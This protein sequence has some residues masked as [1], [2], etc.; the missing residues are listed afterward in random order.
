MNFLVPLML[1]GWVPVA[2][3]F[4]DRLNP[5]HAVLATVIGGWL[6]LP[7]ASYNLAGLPMFDKHTAIALGL[8]MG[9]M[10][11]GPRQSFNIDWH[12]FDLPMVIYCLSPVVT[13]LE[14]GL[15]IY[16]GLS[17]SFYQATTWG[18]PYLAGRVYFHDSDSL[19]DLLMG[20]VIGGLL[21][22]PLCLYEVR[23]SPQLSNIFYGFFPH[24]FAQHMR[25]GGFRPI[26]FLQ[27]GLMVAL[28]MAIA[29]TAAFW[30]WRKRL[31]SSLRGF[32]FPIPVL[33]LSLIVTTILCKSVNG[34]FAL[35]VGCGAYLI[36]RRARNQLPLLFLI[37][38]IPC[39]IALRSTETIPVEQVISIAE[40]FV[41]E[42]RVE[43]F[44]IRLKQEQLFSEKAWTHKYFGW[45]G[46]DRGWPTD[47]YSGE[48][49][50]SMIDSIWIITFSMYGLIGLVS[51]YSS[52]LLGP[53]LA[54]KAAAKQFDETP[55][56]IYSSLLSLIVILF[57][58]DTLFNGMIGP[59]YIVINGALVSC[60]LAASGLPENDKN[61]TIPK[62]KRVLSRRHERLVTR[63]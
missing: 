46:Y 20:I 8:V 18:I 12:I 61:E 1:F 60:H 63:R 17:A 26:V 42:E 52:M 11:S 33:V 4:F 38:A 28:W 59:I 34:W 62:T 25:F 24:S 21:Y 30:L 47:P 48:K 57:M 45:G 3:L 31:L 49:L 53:W 2:L 13:S 56:G 54:L 55:E 44:A 10:L 15:G 43:S 9:R 7:Q 32:I 37:L 39:Y 19:R 51:L 58:I 16:D 50:I 6:F 14:N 23:M 29:S 35:L 41:D 22:V 40:K 27:H 5:R 36:T